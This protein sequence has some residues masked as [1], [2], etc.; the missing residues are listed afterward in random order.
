ML[1]AT[2][3]LAGKVAVVTGAGRG[4]G[5]GIARG[6]AQAGAHLCLIDINADE[7]AVTQ[8]EIATDAAA[9]GREALAFTVDVSDFSQMATAVEQVVARWGRLDLLVSNAAIMPLV[10]FAD[11]TPALWE[12]MMAVNLTGV[13]NGVKAVWPQM[14]AQGGG[15][16]VAIASGSSVRG[17]V[18]E[19]AYCTAKHGLEGFSKALAMESEA[20]SIAVNTMGPGKLIK[21]TSISRV[22][23]DQAEPERRAVWT[24]PLTLA[25]AF[26]WLALQP[27]ARY[28]GLR[29]DAG[30]LA[31]TI[32]AEGYDFAF[33]PAKVTRY[34]EDFVARCE[35]RARWTTLKVT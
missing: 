28:T 29:F 23:A 25:P 7:L 4:F 10:S 12:K 22:E 11:T 13:F 9:T 32:A 27:P 30:P 15:H 18:D 16:C 20:H 1:D 19:V 17:F 2:K 24:D 6:L 14:V 21:P 3:L 26:V 31:D 34:V 33:A 5:A 8:R 35:E